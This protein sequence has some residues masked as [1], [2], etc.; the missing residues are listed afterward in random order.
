VAVGSF[1][2]GKQMRNEAEHSPPPS[3]MVRN[4][5]N[6]NSTPPIYPHAVERERSNFPFIDGNKGLC[7]NEQIPKKVFGE[8]GITASKY[9]DMN[10][11]L[12]T[13]AV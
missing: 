5:W 8:S 4:Q 7:E 9:T 3:V 11:A 2:R 6:F 13:T 10:C 12:Q 1:D